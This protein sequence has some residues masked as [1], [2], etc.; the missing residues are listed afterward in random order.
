MAEEKLVKAE[1]NSESPVKAA[2]ASKP[3]KPKK[4]GPGL[5]KRIG[6]FLVDCKS[7][8]KKV[9]W[10]SREETVKQTGVAVVMMVVCGLV[11]GALDFL[12]TNLIL[13]LGGLL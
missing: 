8:M 10:L 12:L 2:K 3:E 7:E 1:E 4:K 9:V 13:L 6:G 11:V 5:F